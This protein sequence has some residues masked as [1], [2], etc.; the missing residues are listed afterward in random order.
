MIPS[1]LIPSLPSG[2]STRCRS[3]NHSLKLFDLSGNS[4]GNFRH[5][6]AN[7]TAGGMQSLMFHP[8]SLVLAS[9]SATSIF[10]MKCDNTGKS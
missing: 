7:R 1:H 9:A 4:V 2:P 3:K 8:H 10:L 5:T 6:L